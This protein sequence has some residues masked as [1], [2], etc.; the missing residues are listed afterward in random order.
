[1]TGDEELLRQAFLNIV[2]NACQAM[3]QGSCRHEHGFG[4]RRAVQVRG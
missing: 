1:V 4:G 3:R 2:Q